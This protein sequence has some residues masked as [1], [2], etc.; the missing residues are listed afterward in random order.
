[1]ELVV[2]EEPLLNDCVGGKPKQ[3]TCISTY[4]ESAKNTVCDVDFPCQVK[5]AYTSSANSDF[6]YAGTETQGI[7]LPPKENKGDVS[8]AL[9][10]ATAIL[11]G[12]LDY[13]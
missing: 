2:K 8:R 13:L 7:V 6:D 1:M 9:F 11:T 5:A 10:E 4:P 3:R 12:S